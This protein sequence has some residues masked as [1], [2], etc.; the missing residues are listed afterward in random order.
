MQTIR[1]RDGLTYG[2]YASL[3]THERWTGYFSI[4]ASFAPLLYTQGVEQTQKELTHFLK[5]EITDESISR[6]KTDL[7][8]AHVV[9]LTTS[10]S[11][12]FAVAEAL[13]QG[14]EPDYIDSYADRINAVTLKQVQ[15]AALLLEPDKLVVASAGTFKK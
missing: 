9:S 7:I 10:D 4:N 14:F 6:A 3:V 8:G 11:I 15:E 1:E 5:N 2:I 13:E 12:L